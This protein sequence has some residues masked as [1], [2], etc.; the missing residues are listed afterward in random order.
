MRIR[1]WLVSGF[2]MIACMMM[3]AEAADFRYAAASPILTLDPHASTDP[4]TM[5]VL[6][7]VYEALV[8]RDQ[9]LNLTP[10]LATAWE[11]TGPTNWRFTL[12]P[13][14]RFDEGQPFTAADAKFSIE[15]AS[16]GMFNQFTTNI[17]SVTVVDDHTL[18]VQTKQPDPLPPRWLSAISIVSRDW[19]TAHD[20]QRAT[21]I[22]SNQEQYIVWHAN[23]T[24]MFKLA[25]WDAGS[26]KVT[27][28]R[29]TG[30]WGQ[31]AGNVTHAEFVP[32]ASGP[33][34]TA[35]LLAGD[36]DLLRDTP[37]AD[38]LRIKADPGFKVLDR[39][40]FRQ[41]MLLMSPAPDVL[42]D[43]WGNDGKPLAANPWRDV[44]VRQAVAHAIDVNLIISRI[45]QGFAVPAAVASAKGLDGYQEALDKPY[46]F[47][48]ALSR[49]LLADAGY[50]DGFRTQLQCTNDRYPNDEAVCRAITSMLA[51]VGIKAE[52][53]PRP[54]KNFVQDLTNLRLNFLL[55][56][57][58]PNG[59]TT[60]DLL[61]STYMTRKGSEGFLNWS[62]W[63]DP[64]FDADIHAL[65]G[66]FDPARRAVLTGD[67][68]ALA[69]DE[70]ASD[71]L[72]T[73]TVNWAMKRN[74]TAA[75][76]QDS[77]VMLQ[78][79]NVD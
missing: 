64:K 50:P 51:R 57:Q 71:M 47:D 5:M 62:R 9:N 41:M 44:R 59:Q 1:I 21:T 79:V 38:V 58:L 60:F 18:D 56:G 45:M 4:V 67:A 2:V 34:R 52:P 11:T 32:I 3:R 49:R 26:G 13:D 53:M 29:N 27:L 69:H 63:S 6:T 36:V 16:G 28:E 30:W 14:V 23:G 37:T 76:R 19:A 48:A 73:E 8:G 17:A 75:V 12:R 39:S 35:A 24:G 77:Y 54:W 61:L 7:N 46:G 33:T 70:V 66:D 55:I 15:R 31:S 72:Y 74:I 42:P 10:G 78:W 25:N 43:A 22:S 68:L 65:Q 20:S 40:S